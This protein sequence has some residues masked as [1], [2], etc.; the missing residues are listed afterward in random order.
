MP[1]S[2]VGDLL[3]GNIPTPATA[4]PEKYVADAAD[5]IDS[6]IGFIYQT[7]IDVT[8]ASAVKKPARLLLKRISN[9]LASGRLMMAAAAGSQ[10]LEVHAYANKLIAD[11]TAA[12]NAIAS[13]EVQLDGAV[14][15]DDPAE[16]FTGPQIYNQDPESTVEAFYDRV[17]NPNYIYPPFCFPPAHPGN[18]LVR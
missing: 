17:A 11:A 10:K 13:G 5:E 3:T 1:Y 7:P 18:G 9:W 4:S 6:V 2:D 15:L 14:R 12:L 8:E 16:S